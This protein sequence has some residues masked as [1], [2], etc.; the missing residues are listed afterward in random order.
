MKRQTC[1][2][3]YGH[4]FFIG[5]SESVPELRKALQCDDIVISRGKQ[6]EDLIDRLMS[7]SEEKRGIVKAISGEYPAIRLE[8][9][10]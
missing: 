4:V 10:A 2:N 8:A 9:E 7:E 6:L 1:E 5:N 3:R